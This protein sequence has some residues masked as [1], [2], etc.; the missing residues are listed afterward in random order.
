MRKYL[1]MMLFCVAMLCGAAN[2]VP[3]VNLTP[4]PMSIS[5]SDGSFTIPADY[6][7]AVKGLSEQMKDEC[8]A[9]VNALNAATGLNGSV[10]DKSHGTFTISPKGAEKLGDEGYTL[11][12]AHK[13]VRIA[14]NTPA[15]LFY[16]FQSIKKMLPA[17]VMAGVPAEAGTAYSLPLVDIR[18]TPR[19]GYR[20]FMLDVSRHFFDVDEIKKMLDV[21]SWYKLNKFHW[22]LSDDQGWR[23]Q[24]DKY[25]ELTGIGATAPNRRFTDMKAKKQYWSNRP[26]GPFFYTKDQIRNIIDYARQRHIEVIPEFDMPGHFVAALCAYPEFSCNPDARREVWADGGIST[27]VLNVADPAAVGFV[28]DILA[29]VAEVFPSP[30][31][32]IGGDECPTNA[33]QNNELCQQVYNNEKM[34]AWSQLQSR[35]VKEIGDYLISL[36]KQ[37]MVWNESI[38]AGGA[39]TDLIK[40]LDAT[41]FCWTG[42]DPAAELGTSLGLRCIY[43]PWGPYYINR[44][45]DPNDPPGAGG[46]G[47]VFDH[48][49]RT[50]ETV[51]FKTVDEGKSDFCVGVQGT[52][53]C[54]HVSDNEYMEYLALP[55]L[56]AIA[57]AGWTPQNLK[58]FDDFQKRM[59]ADRQ[60]L[61]LGGYGYSTYYMLDNDNQ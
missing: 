60:L 43:T 40:K 10:I 7:V 58:D 38:T 29:E 31:I 37:P 13:D 33:W 47:G 49:K 25:P 22:H 48:V 20:G 57:E 36:G 12:V 55:R 61:D 56:I 28:K 44:R 54:E 2:N 9:F 46:N 39:N 41:V 30:Y 5:V 15:G 23:M 51:P 16:A 45:Q 21:M 18:D 11:R 59:T 14:A 52:F 26:Y 19:Y 17:N 53:W 24:I 8:T 35:F 50:Y 3:Q 1:S 42:A 32:H 4:R 34:S 27:D 6:T